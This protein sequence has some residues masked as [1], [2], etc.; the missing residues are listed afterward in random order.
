MRGQRLHERTR[1]I[2][3]WIVSSLP[4]TAL[5]GTAHAQSSGDAREPT[6]LTPEL[7]ARGYNACYMPETGFGAYSTWHS[8]GMGLLIVPLTGGRTEDGGYDVVIHF[9]G[10]E[11]VRR[12]FVQ[13]ARGTVLVG[14]DLGASSGAYARAFEQPWSFVTLLG[15]VTRTLQETSGDPRAH[16][17]HLGISSWSA[18]FGAVRPILD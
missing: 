14:I 7:R 6:A 15:R 8:V 11:A 9:H 5:L 2:V 13:A 18:G 3:R 12:P 16:I 1:R 4:L 17:R 10:H